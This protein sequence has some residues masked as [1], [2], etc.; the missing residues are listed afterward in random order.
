MSEV[1]AVKFGLVLEGG[2]MRGL[3][4]AGAMDSLMEA[5]IKFDGIIGV[6][7]G[8]CFG[9]NYKSGQIGRTLRYNKLLA[10]DSRYC[11]LKS[12]IKTGDLFGAD[13]C[14]REVPEVIDPFDNEAFEKNP[15]EFYLVAT[16]CNSGEPVYKKL[17]SSRGE[18]SEWMRAS[19]SMP[20][21]SRPVRIDGLT[22][23]DGGLSDALP[24][25]Y[26]EGLGFKKNVVITTRPY[27]Y[28]KKPSR[29]T[30]MAKPFLAKY[31]KIYQSLKM[32][33]LG[34]NNAIS[35]LEKQVADGHALCI[36]P[37]E[38][39]PISRICHNP[40]Q[41]QKAYDIGRAAGEM[42]I[43]SIRTFMNS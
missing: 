14:Y 40:E 19:A 25:A 26:F 13:F 6:S 39:L 30:P 37:S 5:G 3:F 34:Y 43:S 11:S 29:F 27:G 16:D 9:C 32:R 31:P 35:Y 12:L 2:A 24:L 38:P 15:T 20:I 7:A 41:M 1:S 17:T 22:L 18:C 8:A 42:A 28:R 21:V 33:H 10:N 36:A 23:L 4:S